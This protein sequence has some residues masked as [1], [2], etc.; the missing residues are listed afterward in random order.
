MRQNGG[1][2]VT[3]TSSVFV[4]ETEQQVIS[5]VGPNSK[6]QTVCFRAEAARDLGGES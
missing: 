2:R 6:A 3:K 5:A 1:E 4:L